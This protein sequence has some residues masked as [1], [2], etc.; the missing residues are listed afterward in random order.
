MHRVKL[1]KAA[2]E[3]ALKMAAKIE[4][5]LS[6]RQKRA[7]ACSSQFALAETHAAFWKLC[8]RHLKTSALPSDALYR[9]A[10]DVLAKGPKSDEIA[11]LDAAAKLKATFSGMAQPEPMTTALDTPEGQ[12][13][14][15]RLWFNATQ[16]DASVYRTADKNCP[17]LLSYTEAHQ[18]ALD[19]GIKWDF[20]EAAACDFLSHPEAFLAWNV[21][22][23]PSP[24]LTSKKDCAVLRSK[25]RAALTYKGVS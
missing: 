5:P 18:E 2:Q 25:A 11:A 4:R 23:I 22:H 3:K 10:S 1:S 6:L 13:I 16:V 24:Y 9:Y 20:R 14:A 8:V 17:H 12:S 19:E 15:A 21:N 7:I